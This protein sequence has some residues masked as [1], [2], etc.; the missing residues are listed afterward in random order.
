MVGRSLWKFA[1]DCFHF[2]SEDR[3]EVWVFEKSE[4]VKMLSRG[5]GS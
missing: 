5:L 3:K 4:S 1:S 2:L